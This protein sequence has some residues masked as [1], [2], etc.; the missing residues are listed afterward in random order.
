MKKILFI[1]GELSDADVDW[2]LYA[3][4]RERLSIGK[5]LIRE[6]A[7]IEAVFIV[8]T[9]TLKVSVS[10]LA[11]HEIARLS[12]GEVVGEISFLD[13]RLPTATVTAL[14]DCTLLSIPRQQLN[15]KLSTDLG[16]ASRFYRAIALSLSERLRSTVSLLGN[17]KVL[18]SEVPLK[19]T[20]DLSP[21]VI[22]HLPLARKRF[23]SLLRRLRD[24]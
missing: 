6:G 20:D 23:D 22:E 13:T 2:I 4:R 15:H 24:Y 12:S 11:G 9:G 7:A 19:L 14:E 21:T 8:L 10:H 16:F 18:P 5:V 3:G 17:G 1:L